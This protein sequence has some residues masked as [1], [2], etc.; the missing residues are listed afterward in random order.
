[1]D[2]V[3]HGDRLTREERQERD[4]D[5]LLRMQLEGYDGPTWHDEVRPDVWAYAYRVLP[6]KIET[7]EIF[8]MRARLC[9]KPANDLSLPDE[10]ICRAD[11]EDLASDVAASAITPFQYQLKRGVWDVSRDITFRSWFINLCALRFAAP[12]RKWLRERDRCPGAPDPGE[13]DTEPEPSSVI[14]VVEFERYLDRVS[15]PTTKAMI[16]MDIAGCSDVDIAEVTRTT[17]KAV[18]GRLARMRQDARRLRDREA[19]RDRPRDFG[20]GVA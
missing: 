9:G 16:C 8:A 14:Y 13:H 6:K 10:G 4:R 5:R 11:A 18:E 19:L 12:Y 17:V 15:D 1:M 7:G 2:F 20:S 3:I